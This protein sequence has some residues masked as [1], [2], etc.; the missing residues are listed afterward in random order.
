ME[1]L[2]LL[3]RIKVLPEGGKALDVGPRHFRDSLKLQELGFE[4]T[5]IEPSDKV[6]A[7]DGITNLQMKLE[8]VELDTYN[9]IVAM[10]VLPFVD[11]S[12]AHLERLIEALTPGGVLVFSL[13]GP[14]HAWRHLETAEREGIEWVLDNYQL[15]VLQR[16]EEEGFMP[17]YSGDVVYWHEY[18][19][20]V[21]KN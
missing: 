7:P 17:T 1:I 12:I 2:D 3:E 19:Y 16:K 4:V 9:V 11:D 8:D 5:T 14:M 20:A 13:F 6:R 18:L 21:K 15:E 10:K